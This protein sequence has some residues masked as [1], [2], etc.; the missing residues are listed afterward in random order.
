MGDSI[1]RRKMIEAMKDYMME[2]NI[3]NLRAKIYSNDSTT[4]TIGDIE[5]EMDINSGIKQG[6]TASTTLFK[7]VTFK[8]MSSIELR[9]IEYEIEGQKIT[10]LF[11]AVD[12]LAM[13]RTLEAAKKNLRIIEEDS[14]KYGLE[15]NKEKSSILVYNN[16]ENI[17]EID[18]IKVVNKIEYLGLKIDNERDIFKS[19]KIDL[20]DRAGKAASRTYSVIKR[21]CNKMLI[22]KTYWKGEIIPSVLHGIGLMNL[23]GEDTNKLQ[24]IENRV[25]GTILGARKG[26][27][28]AA[29]RGEVGALLVSTRNMRARIN[30]AHSIWN[31]KNEMVKEVLRRIRNDKSNPWS[32]RLNLYLKKLEIS[33]EQMVGM[34]K[35]QIVRRILKYDSIRWYDDMITKTSLG[36]Y[37]RKKR[38]IEDEIIYYKNRASELLFRARSNTMDLNTDK[39]HRGE[40]ELCDL[41][42][43]G[44]ENLKHFIYWNVAD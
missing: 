29:I 2:P 1:D 3:I 28:I 33:F 42:E 18:G 30:L 44:T 40:S 41:C 22:G 37:S 12:S 24:A 15:L 31:G 25:Y 20:I 38:E 9:G 27:P 10:T 35:G 7:I 26:T 8:I 34:K 11:F 6:C 23:S 39:R 17:E 19:Q 32:R 4:V 13:A 14:R 43:R 36:I 16:K 21:S 5:E